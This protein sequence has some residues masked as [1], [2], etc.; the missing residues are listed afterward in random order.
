MLNTAEPWLPGKVKKKAE[1]SGKA[2]LLDHCLM[3]WQ[4]EWALIT[5]C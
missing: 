1:R 5:E 3:E 2:L 4:S